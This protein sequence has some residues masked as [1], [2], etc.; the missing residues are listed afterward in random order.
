MKQILLI[1]FCFG[2]GFFA[3]NNKPATVKD[4]T[5]TPKTAFNSLFFDSVQLD[6]FLAK[7]QELE[8]FKE[9][10]SA[11]YKQRNYQFAWIDVKG[12][13]EQAIHLANLVNNAVSD[14]QDSSIFIGKFNASYNQVLVEG[15]ENLE[16]ERILETE[17]L[18]TG[19][20]F[21]YV[22]KVY[23][24]MDV[25]AEELGWFIPR[26]KVDLGKLLDTVIKSKDYKVDSYL[27][28]NSRYYRL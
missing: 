9:Q 26:K 13:D 4:V 16:T 19:Q 25:N 3:C 1:S 12:F 18:L 10:Y 11:F 6:N 17:L 20:F 15:L 2:I 14:L 5:I 8:K 27:P 24:G 28:F 7:N 22:A 23:K 21:N